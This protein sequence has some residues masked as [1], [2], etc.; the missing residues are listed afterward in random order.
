MHNFKKSN[1]DGVL[2]GVLNDITKRW[3]SS[4]RAT[5]T[6]VKAENEKATV[7]AIDLQNETVER[8]ESV[9]LFPQ[10]IRID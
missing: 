5:N 7:A 2:V 6:T 1:R 8:S 10:K 3:I 9:R 4:V